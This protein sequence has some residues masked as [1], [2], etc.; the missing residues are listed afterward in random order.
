MSVND[1]LR[2]LGIIYCIAFVVSFIVSCLALW[3]IWDAWRSDNIMDLLGTV[4]SVSGG[5]ALLTI[6]GWEGLKHLMVLFAAGR[7]KK[8]KEEGREE[9]RQEGIEQGRKEGM[10]E[11]RQEERQ[12]GKP[13]I[14][15]SCKPRP[16]ASP[17]TNRPRPK[18]DPPTRR[19]TPGLACPCTFPAISAG[20][21]NPA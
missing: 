15:G 1:Q 5:M 6:I 13:G 17:S 14:S 4:F 8:L 9:G 11:G 20:M 12:L 10:A 16:T 19:I 3:L 2:S 18:A 7:I 21:F